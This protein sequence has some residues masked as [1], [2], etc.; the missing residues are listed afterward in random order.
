MGPVDLHPPILTSYHYNT[1]ASSIDSGQRLHE[2]TSAGAGLCPT[3]LHA[4]GVAWGVVA[5]YAHDC[6]GFIQGGRERGDF[7]PLSKIPPPPLLN[8][9]KYYKKV[10]L[11]RKQQ[12]SGNC[13]SKRYAP[14][15]KHPEFFQKCILAQCQNIGNRHCFLV[16]GGRQM[17]FPP[18]SKN[19]V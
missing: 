18:F 7:P 4:C 16:G 19:P 8:Q 3:K 9:H 1:E 2:D 17:V 15:Q 14:I 6:Q 11:K 13:C 5:E 12:Q 10:V